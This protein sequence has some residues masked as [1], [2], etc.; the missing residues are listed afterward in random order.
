MGEEGVVNRVSEEVGFGDGGS[1]IDVDKVTDSLES[2]KGDADRKESRDNDYGEMYSGE[3]RVRR[4]E[5]KKTVFEIE[6]D[7]EIADKCG[8][9]NKEAEKAFFLFI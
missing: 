7:S 4:G 3:K 1:S 9:E 8:A 5:E 2:D 6:E